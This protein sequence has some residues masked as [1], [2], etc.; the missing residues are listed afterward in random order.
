VAQLSRIGV[1]GTGHIAQHF[2]RALTDHE[3]FEP[4]VVLTRRPLESMREV[5]NTSATHSIDELIE[6]S[7]LIVEC[8]GDAVHASDVAEAAVVAGIPVV[9]MDAEFQVTTA[10][11]FVGRGIVTEAEGDQPGSLA[12][13]AA[14]AREM[15]FRPVV[16]G[17]MKG[18]LNHDPQ[19]EEMQYWAA[20]QGYSVTMTTAF[21]DG[22]KLNVE[23]VLVANGLRAAIIQPGLLGPASDDFREGGLILARYAES[24]GKP[25]SDYVLSSRSTHGVF[26]MATHHS[27]HAAALEN[28]KL[29]PG[30]HYLLMRPDILGYLEIM[31]TV[32]RV[33][34][35][36]ELLLDNSAE[37]A[38]SVAAIA[39]RAVP[40]GTRIAAAYGGFDFRGIA[41][42]IR[43]SAGHAP[44][45]LMRDV[46]VRRNLA[47]GEMVM[48]DDLE[49][50]DSV[51]TRAWSQIEGRVLGAA[52]LMGVTTA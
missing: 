28:Y 30:P 18:F 15:G 45:G 44:I 41:V 40:A 9:T 1:V 46:V 47:P 42:G 37:P 7:D 26:L 6:K 4:S 31:K 52:S 22:S 2:L 29:G 21:T 50:P 11:A 36:Q 13:L 32:K 49:M 12:A 34:R 23:Q 24:L 16:Y 5:E 39:K 43:E 17:N 19:P 27:S 38:W 51:A 20:R 10:S 33:V 48:C 14:D 35:G 8:S 3:G 25:V